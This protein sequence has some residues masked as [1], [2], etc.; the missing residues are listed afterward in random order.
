MREYIEKELNN[1]EYDLTILIPIYNAED[2]ID[3]TIKSVINQ[4]VKNITYEVVLL[5][6]GSIDQSEEICKN[7]V[8]RYNNFY[9]YHHENH[10]VSFT[11]NRGLDLAQGKYILF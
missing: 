11:R 3:G 4:K 2:F 9:Y 7:Y 10:G 6:D 1:Y 8:E 5:N